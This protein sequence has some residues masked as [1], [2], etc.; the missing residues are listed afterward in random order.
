MGALAEAKAKLK[1]AAGDLTDNPDLREGGAQAEMRETGQE[2][3]EKA[4]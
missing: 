3:A 4:R 2:V 1:Q